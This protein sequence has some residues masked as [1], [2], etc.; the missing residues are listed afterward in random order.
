[1]ANAKTELFVRKQSGGMYTVVNEALTTGS[2]FFVNSGTGTD[3]AGNGKNPD[4]PFATINYAYTQCTDSKFDRIYV[5]PG[6]T[7][8]IT[9]AAGVAANKI[10]V[11][12]IG[13][14]TGRLRPTVNYTTAIAAS[15][16]VSA[17]SN[18]ISNIIF[19]PN[20][21]DAITAAMNVTAADFWM[22]N[23]E[24]DICNTAADKQMVL[25]ILTAATA[26]RFKV[27]NTKFRGPATVT[28]TTCTACIKHEV[29]VDFDI[30][31]CDFH[32]KMTQAI[33]NATTV[34][35]GKIHDNRFQIYTGTK[36]IALAA[37]STA[38]ITNN[39]FNVPS[40]T[41]PIVAAAGFVAGNVYSAA[42]G[43]TAG[44][45]STL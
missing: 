20:G 22:D 19:T 32:G 13:L 41:A 14:G 30:S 4:A 5:M 34:L 27:T 15:F 43:V 36:G 8:T 35:G 17:A 21:F 25:G 6:H 37:A 40:G 10:G 11:S 33:L 44:T 12:L 7:E 45:A 24:W 39:R 18:Y 3:S 9:G 42:A 38:L 29:G 2:I 16:D 1:M 31:G 26:T 28:G 23:C